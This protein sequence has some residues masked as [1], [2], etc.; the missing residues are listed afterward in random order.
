MKENM[1]QNASSDLTRSAE[2]FSIWRCLRSEWPIWC[3][4]ALLSASA[5]CRLITGSF[6]PMFDAPYAYQSD[7]LSHAW[8]IQRLIEGWL[9]DNPR[10]GYPFGSDFL[11]YPNA[12]FSNLALL[13]ILALFT[14]KYY[15]LFDIYLLLT[16]VTIFVAAYAVL[17]RLGLYRST[18]FV[19]AALFDFL[20]FHFWREIHLFFTWY[21]VVPVYV[22]VG[23]S[24]YGNESASSASENRKWLPVVLKV[25]G[26]LLLASFGFYFTVFGLITIAFSAIAGAAR[27]GS[28]KP[29]LRGGA[30]AFVLCVGVIANVVPYVWHIHRH[31]TDL[32]VAARAAEQGEVLAFKPIQL[33]LPQDHYRVQAVAEWK[34]TYNVSSPLTNENSSASLG[35]IGSMG[36]VLA[37]A[38]L[39]WLL[40]GRA[41]SVELGFLCL[42]TCVYLA[43]GTIG[44]AGAVVSHVMPVLRGWN[45]ISV[46]VGFV[47]LAIA[48]LSY[49]KFALKGG[50]RRVALGI[51]G[52]WIMLGLAL[53]DQ[54]TPYYRLSYQTGKSSFEKDRLFIRQIEN[55]LPDGSAVYQLPYMRFPE[56]PPVFD[57]PSYGLLVGFLNSRHLKWSFAGMAGR[58]GDVFYE[59]LAQEPIDKQVDV[60]RRLGFS[61]VYLDRRGFADHGAAT[62][63]ELTA[64]LGPP[65]LARSDGEA[66]FFDLH[67]HANVNVA[68]LTAQQIMRK[69]GFFADKLGARYP[70]TY[71]SGI[72][73]SRAGWP[74]FIED[75]SGIGGNEPWGRWSSGNEVDLTFFEPLPQRFNLDLV[76]TPFGPNTGKDLV[77]KIGSRTYKV[78]IPAANY[79]VSL[80]VDLLGEKADEIKLVP[81][82]VTSPKAL[83]VSEDDRT[84]AIGLIHLSIVPR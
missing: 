67:D 29:I 62:V 6:I 49:Q 55:S 20:P 19:A 23:F 9:Y 66:V 77:V 41:V 72:D 11:D 10:S 46:F 15:A 27:K 50:G 26:L 54:T 38:L 73:F 25:A 60:I 40:A 78:N 57:L 43:F 81:A 80:P 32:E 82:V 30:I 2:D 69:A 5:A 71:A 7:A 52:L 22:A 8:F 58:E 56:S 36:L 68:G 4:G 64:L 24:L 34:Q 14:G 79:H 33:V 51:A 47:A 76:V 53:A 83:G 61:G 59:N 39:L 13:K 44:G 48:F 75:A 17:R 31:G 18:A 21:A 84:I 1:N 63:A 3:V 74:D 35:V 37:A 45:R 42:L 65:V 16:F 70:A 28:W 12:D